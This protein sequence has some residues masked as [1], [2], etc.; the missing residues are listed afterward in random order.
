M[1]VVANR[2]LRAVR[3]QL[4]D[5]SQQS[6]ERPALGA[7]Q[8]ASGPWSVV[9]SESDVAARSVNFLASL[10]RAQTDVEQGEPCP[11]EVA[12]QRVISTRLAEL[13]AS[14]TDM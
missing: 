9:T 4:R 10:V 2:R 6:H 1:V 14:V 12:V 11:G 3:N 13:G 5:V 8:Y 7:H